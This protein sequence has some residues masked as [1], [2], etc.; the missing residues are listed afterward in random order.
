LADTFSIIIK[1]LQNKPIF[2]TMNTQGKN[3]IKRVAAID[4]GTNSFHA[5]IVDIFPDGSF[6]TIDKLK[7]MVLLAEKGFEN[8]LS[9]DAMQRAVD[10][11]KRIKTLCDHQG[12]EKILA[13][14]TSAIREAENGGELIQRVIDEVGIKIVAI[15]GRVEAEL[16]GLA[17]QHGVKMP[18]TPSMI[19]DIGG[20]SVEFLI[21][22]KKKFYYVTSLKLGVARM[23]AKF[24]D[25]D[26]ITQKEI[27]QLQHYYRQQLSEVAQ[28][29]ALHRGSFLIGSS[30]TME[31][32][33]LMIANRNKTF[34]S[35][36]VNEL[37]FTSDDF[38]EFYDDVIKMNYSQR[39]NLKGLDEKRNNLL[40][41]GLILVDYI[42]HNFGIKKVKIS[43]QALREG[44]ILRYID[45]ELEELREVD[46]VPDPRRRSVLELAHKCEWHE[47]HSKHVAKIALLIFDQFNDELELTNTDRELL[48]YAAYLHD[49]GYHISHRKHHKHALYIIRNA[50]LKGFREN[51]IEIIANVA[52]YHR[53]STPK[54]RHH[55]FEKLDETDKLRVKKLSAIMRIADGLDR[56]HYQNVRAVDFVKNGQE[57]IIKINTEA[58]PQLEIW[59][60]MRK[61]LLFEEMTGRKL[62]IKAEPVTTHLL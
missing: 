62:S 31:N 8:S 7:E 38:F 2:T 14:A 32:I 35:L 19:M 47:K 12:T 13:Y 11:L 17:V 42:L 15:P 39:A 30:G 21:A 51:E 28:S 18:R 26:P 55:H 57:T 49:I 9:E 45:R 5:V 4:L 6:Y 27:E 33:A 58:D 40:P 54:P 25:N 34:P 1:I 29:F 43:S 59:G 56:S 44:I 23:T 61:N 53:R 24:V 41:A 50:D 46:V 36:T 37:A 48:E 16:I 22:D 20:G 52:R 60:A 3:P 10:A